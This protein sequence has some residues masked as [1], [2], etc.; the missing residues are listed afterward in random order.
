MN[1]IAFI[2][3]ALLAATTAQARS[4]METTVIN[5]LRRSGV[6]EDCLAKVTLNDAA[7]INSWNNDSEMSNG[8]KNRLTR[9]TVRKICAR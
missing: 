1:R 2:V 8:T 7:K 9:D 6:P 4:N 3:V 5:D